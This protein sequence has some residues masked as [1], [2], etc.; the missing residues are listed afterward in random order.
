MIKMNNVSPTNYLK[1]AL[2]A[3]LLFTLATATNAQTEQKTLPINCATAE[4]DIRALNAEKEHAKKQQALDVTAITPAGALIGLIA[5][6][7][8]KKLEILS[9]DYMKQIDA[10]IAQIHAKCGE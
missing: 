5:G 2:A 1:P 8:N 7:E 4:G 3:S 10:R 9:G 6:N